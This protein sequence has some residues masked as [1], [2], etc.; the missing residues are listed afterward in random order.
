MEAAGSEKMT[1]AGSMEVTTAGSEQM[2]A[3]SA[4][5]ARGSAVAVK[6]AC[7]VVGSTATRWRRAR[8]RVLRRRG[9]P[10]DLRGLVGGDM[11]RMRDQDVDADSS[12]TPTRSKTPL[13]LKTSPT[14]CSRAVRRCGASRVHRGV[15]GAAQR[16]A[17]RAAAP[18]RRRRR[19]DDTAGLIQ[20]RRFRP[21]ARAASAEL[22]P[23]SCKCATAT[24]SSADTLSLSSAC[25]C[26]AP[27]V[28]CGELR[29]VSARRSVQRARPHC[30]SALGRASEP[31]PR[32]REQ[33][34][35]PGSERA[36]RAGRAALGAGPRRAPAARA[37]GR[38][39]GA[40]R[41]S[42]SC[43]SSA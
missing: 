6:A 4:E 25:C 35:R 9:Q 17:H 24:L 8:R 10:Q 38:S 13:P 12:G 19:L 15:P 7:S 20:T 14:P 37:R 30:R 36:S 27:S 32:L 31:R 40:E 16:A 28:S 42:G 22:V 34:L 21:G 23:L 11:P 3:G 33:L 39:R 2:T 18:L 29:G 26:C 43:L 1:I 41:R 5:A